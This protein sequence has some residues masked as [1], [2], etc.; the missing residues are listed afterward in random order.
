MAGAARGNLGDL[1]VLDVYSSGGG[2]LVNMDPARVR[3]VRVSPNHR[4]VPDDATG[5]VIERGENRIAG[6]LTQVELGTDTRQLVGPHDAG[7]DSLQ[8][9]YFG[10][11]AHGVYRSIGVRQS[12]MPPLTEHDVKI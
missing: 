11:P 10:A 12:Q 4:V 7:V 5:W 8:A 6:V 3:L 9:V 2:V 1:A